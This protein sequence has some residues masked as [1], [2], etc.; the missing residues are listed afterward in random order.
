MADKKSSEDG[1]VQLRGNTK[2]RS[3]ERS[4]RNSKVSGTSN[5]NVSPEIDDRPLSETSSSVVETSVKMFSLLKEIQNSIKEQDKTLVTVNRLDNL[6]QNNNYEGDEDYFDYP[7]F[8]GDMCR[9]ET[10][11]QNEDSVSGSKLKRESIDDTLAENVHDLFRSG[12][13]EERYSELVKDEINCR[14][15]DCEALVVLKTNPCIWDGISQNVCTNDKKLQNIETSVVKAGRKSKDRLTIALEPEAASLYCHLLPVEKC[16]SDT[17]SLSTLGP[18]RRY[19]V[20]DAGGGTVDI[21]VHEVTNGGCLKELTKASGG[22]W[23]GTKVDE[24]FFEFMSK[25][26]G[27]H[28]MSVFKDKHTEDYVELFRCFEVKK[29]EISTKTDTQVTTSLPL[30]L[31]EL[32]EKY[33]GEALQEIIKHTRHSPQVKR[34]DPGIVKGFFEKSIG[35]IVKHVKGLLKESIN[36]DVEAIVMV[37]GFSESPLLQENFRDNFP[38][39]KI[40]VPEENGLAVLKGAVVFGHNPATISQRRLSKGF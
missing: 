22:A 26:A 37:G 39:L 1:E 19:M 34:V 24:A 36:S 11:N 10:E 28:V 30:T 38:N 7:S 18:G 14:P 23:G 5:K 8:S 27:S 32:V 13:E 9:V 29:R 35:N 16:G 31:L 17:T 3:S 15:E 4:N 2:E 21:T 25:L 6:E 12:I 20:L 40:I 33:Q